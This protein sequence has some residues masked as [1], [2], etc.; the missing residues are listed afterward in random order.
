VIIAYTFLAKLEVHKENLVLI[1]GL[2]LWKMLRDFTSMRKR[3][4]VCISARGILRQS[5]MEEEI[6]ESLSL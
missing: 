1:R 4:E 3:S 2:E 5:Q 6:D